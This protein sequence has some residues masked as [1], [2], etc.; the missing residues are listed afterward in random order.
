MILKDRDFLMKDQGQKHLSHANVRKSDKVLNNSWMK[1]G[2]DWMQSQY[3]DKKHKILEG[4][5]EIPEEN[6][7]EVIVDYCVH[8]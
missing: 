7:I 5:K 8:I 2:T 4:K 3:R 1:E 6:K